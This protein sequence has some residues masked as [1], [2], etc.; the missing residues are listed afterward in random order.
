M[1]RI[2]SRE[3]TILAAIIALAAFLRFHRLDEIPPGFQ[4]DQ[5]YY[6]FDAIFLLRGDFFI[7]FR[8]PG[9]SEPLFQYLLMPFVALFGGDTPLGPKVTAGIIGVA[10]I[11]L[12]YGITRALFR[13]TRVALLAALFAAISFW[14]IFYCRY[15][16]RIPLTLFLAT[17]TF[18]FFWRALTHPSTIAQDAPRATLHASRFTQY[19]FTGIFTGLT[20]Y[21][22]P[23][24]RVVPIALV[25][26][27][28]YAALTDRARATYYVK[29]LALAGIIA[30]IVFLPLGIYYLQHPIDFISHTADVSIF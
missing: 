4:F 3:K 8:D 30:T 7:F 12:I 29:G 24:G 26:L 6:V 22:Y 11:F 10:T 9:R 20:L 16:E 1:S 28:A 27:T 15:G 25:L 5:A 18:W 19:A 14:H 17:L 21:T 13:S 2:S 23:S